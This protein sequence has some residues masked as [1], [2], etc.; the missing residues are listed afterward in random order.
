WQRKKFKIKATQISRNAAYI[1]VR[2]IPRN[3]AQR[4][5]WTFYE[6][7]NIFKSKNLKP[8][9]ISNFTASTASNDVSHRR[10]S[11]D[12]IFLVSATNLKIAQF[13]HKID[14][15]P[16]SVRWPVRLG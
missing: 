5:Y 12:I 7:I 11:L 15:A 2:E 10:L 4:R 13:R 9:G 16:A 6:A 14:A 1:G 3:A 8:S